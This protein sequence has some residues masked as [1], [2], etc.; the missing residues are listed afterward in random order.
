MRKH[1]LI[2]G[3]AGFIGCNAVQRYASQGHQVTLID[4]LSRTGSQR[5]LDWLESLNIPDL[6]FVRAD[7]RDADSVLKLFQDNAF[8]LVLHCAAQVAV[9]LSVQDPM[10]DFGVNTQGTLN[11]LEG[12]RK[13]KNPK[14]FFI[15]TSTNK[16]YG[17]LET[18]SIVEDETRYRLVD[19][20]NGIPETQNLDFHSPYG[21][22]K[23]AADQYTR[24]YARIYGLNTVVF[25]Q[26]C[27]YG[28]QQV[29]IE[30]QG[31]IAWFIRKA[32]VGA[33][34]NV[35]GTGK[36][37]RDLLFITDLLD[38]YELAEANMDSTRG[39]IYN[40]G[41][42]P[43]SARSVVEVLKIIKKEFPKLEWKYEPWRAGDQ[44]VYI[45]DVSK[46]E[47]DFGWKPKVS[48]DEGI[49]KLISWAQEHKDTL[50]PL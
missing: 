50:P 18:L 46:A 16:V 6:T 8:D 22:S 3:G 20:P 1:I 23:G 37:V 39:Q 11:M 5:N 45:S 42:G 14:A 24:D 43:T 9:T 35:Y 15:F 4:Q 19:L 40:M 30:D 44:K 21:C 13:G 47:R 49:S 25:R 48:S 26:S 12:L 41:G 32:L 34:V 2:T 17:G 36:Q 10:H 7:I 31:W 29:G 27:I 38:A 28:P 33:S